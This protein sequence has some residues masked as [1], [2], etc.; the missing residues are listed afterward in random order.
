MTYSAA[1]NAGD[2]LSATIAP[3]YSVSI[4]CNVWAIYCPRYVQDTV[5]LSILPLV[6]L[7]GS[8]FDTMELFDV[9]QRA[10][11]MGVSFLGT[12]SCLL[13]LSS[14]HTMD[15]GYAGSGYGPWHQA[16]TVTVWPGSSR[17]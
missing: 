6:Q 12:L 2:G 7:V 8:S 13:T 16:D 3:P 15:G 1:V 14:F 11:S 10:S 9:L 17:T 4:S 5:C